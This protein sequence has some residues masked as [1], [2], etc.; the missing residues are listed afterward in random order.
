[1]ERDLSIGNFTV[2]N[3]S[4]EVV[5]VMGKIERKYDDNIPKVENSYPK[6]RYC[7]AEIYLKDGQKFVSRVDA[8]TGSPGNP[9][10]M[11]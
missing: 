9:L 1:L 6:G 5:D 4:E 10:E 7:I 11:I 3:I 2:N 8:P